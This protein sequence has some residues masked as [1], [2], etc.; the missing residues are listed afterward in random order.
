DVARLDQRRLAVPLETLVL[1]SRP[2]ARK[3][4]GLKLDLDLSPV[5]A[6]LVHPLLLRLDL[7]QDPQQVLHMMADLVADHIGLREL[8]RRAA[9]LTAAEPGLDIL[10]E[11][12]IEIDLLVL[13]TVEWAHGALR[14]AAA[15]RGGL[16]AVEHQDGLAVSPAVLLEDVG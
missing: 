13:G 14:D 7:G 4:V 9:D 11:G 2:H 6:D 16:A 8:A 12:G 5:G 10:E 1:V 3:T 15:G